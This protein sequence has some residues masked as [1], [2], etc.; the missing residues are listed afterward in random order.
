MD[1]L[2]LILDDMHFEG[3]RFVSTINHTPWA[4]HLAMPGV[5]CAHQVIRGQAWL[6]RDDAEPLRLEAGDLVVLPGGMA[7]CIQDQPRSLATVQDMRPL[8]HDEVQPPHGEPGDSPHA[9]QLI[10]THARFDVDM[11][12]PLIR[13]LPPV[14]H[15]RG[16]GD[17]P[18]LW[19]AVGLQFLALGMADQRPGQQAILNRIGDILIMQVIRDHV[20]EVPEGSGNWLSALKDKALS[21]A[22]AHIHQNPRRAWTVPELAQQACLSRSAFAERFTRAGLAVVLFDY[23]GFG[24]SGGQ[25]RN[26]VDGEEHVKDWL[27]AIDAVSQRP[28]VDGQR[29]AI[30][31]SSYSGGHVLKAA[32]QRPGV[33]KAVSSQV[34]F[35]NGLASS[36]LYPIKYQPVAGF[37]ALRDMLRGNQD[38]PLYVPIIAKDGLAALICDECDSG[39][40]K[41]VPPSMAATGNRVAA[42]VFLTLPFYNPGKSA[43]DIQAPVLMIAAERDGLI[44]IAKVREVAATLPHGDYVELKGAD[45][46]S[47]YTGPV[48]EDVVARQTAFLTRKLG[49]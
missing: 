14:L 5:A 22:L 47:P 33:V 8:M 40:R 4:W 23:R 30:W 12:A 21:S 35:V 48:F 11:A 43:K 13:A 31:G 38:E 45:H 3:V 19:L 1:S 9:C 2:S 36:L 18:P 6:V 26:V 20:A 29:L 41:L 16:Q 44:P 42:R 25:P 17:S 24:R 37:Y 15:L 46:F 7:H 27:S 32:A 28:E 49:L 39:Y 34:P 10:S